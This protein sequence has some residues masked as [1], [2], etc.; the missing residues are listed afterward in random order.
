MRDFRDVLELHTRFDFPR[1]DKSVCPESE[2]FVFRSRFLHEELNE[3]H[4]AFESG[5]LV[6]VVDALL[7]FVYV[8]NGTALF[9]GIDRSCSF[10]WATFANARH[11]LGILG[12]LRTEPVIPHLLPRSV[13]HYT[14]EA[15]RA[16]LTLF[17]Q[18][19]YAS[20]KDYPGAAE[21]MI[22]ELRQAADQAYRAATLMGV[23]WAKCWRH[24]A[25]ANL[26]KT[27][28]PVAKRGYIKWDLSKPLGWV[29]PDAKI[30]M[31]L[32][33]EGWEVP[34]NMKIDHV[35]GKVEMV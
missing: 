10:Y 13:H 27:P 21:L 22:A 15:M 1:G 20:R 17:E 14:R 32:M 31:E 25:E 16:H 11:D 23:P 26:Q 7:D 6:G 3:Y 19:Y 18:A 24:V 12:V 5:N 29:A 33:A 8:C 35:S 2:I 34:H 9:V 4:A 28:G 30:A